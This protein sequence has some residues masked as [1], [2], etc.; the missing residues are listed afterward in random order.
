MESGMRPTIQQHIQGIFI[1]DSLA[2]LQTAVSQSTQAKLR[3]GKVFILPEK[4]TRKLA[5]THSF[6]KA[7]PAKQTAG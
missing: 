7:T 6:T 1:Y 5:A 4:G 2:E 3:F